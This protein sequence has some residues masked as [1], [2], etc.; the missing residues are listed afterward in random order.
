MRSFESSSGDPPAE[1]E[2]EG[3]SSPRELKRARILEGA[4]ELIGRFGLEKTTM[5]DIA[6]RAGL[7]TASIYYYFEN[8]E[9]VFAAVVRRHAEAFDEACRRKVDEADTAEAKFVAF[10]LTRFGYLDLM[11]QVTKPAA[12]EAYPRAEEV[13]RE[14]RERERHRIEE[15]LRFGVERGEFAV[16]DVPRLAAGLSAALGAVDRSFVVEGLPAPEEDLYGLLTVF[17]RGLRKG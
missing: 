16:D 1:D 5:E 17:L 9:A 6:S 13:V 4:M 15:I 7:K 10:L 3:A 11:A 8:K 2:V 12:V 14:Y